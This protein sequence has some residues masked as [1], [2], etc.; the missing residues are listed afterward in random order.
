MVD[1]DMVVFA[2]ADERAQVHATAA[3]R[4]VL[5]EP[6][7]PLRGLLGDQIE[8]FSVLSPHFCGIDVGRALV[9]GL[10]EHRNDRQQDLL[11][12]LHGTPSLVRMLVPHWVVCRS[13]QD[14]DTCARARV[15]SVCACECASACAYV[16][17]SQAPWRRVA[18]R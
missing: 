14:R 15:V 5:D 6:E 1:E 11:H 4:I 13:V 3:G 16:S 9:V 7:A 18:V 10:C 2:H 17:A 12:R 8:Q